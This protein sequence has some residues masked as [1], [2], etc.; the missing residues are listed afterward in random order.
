MAAGNY[1]GLLD[2]GIRSCV[3]SLPWWN[4]ADAALHVRR[5]AERRTERRSL[6]LWRWLGRGDS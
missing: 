6:L 3:K 2:D 4:E 1:T 5:R